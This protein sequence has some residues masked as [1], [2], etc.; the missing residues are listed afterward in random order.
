MVKC[1][2]NK[3][4]AFVQPKSFDFVLWL[5]LYEY[6]ELLE[7]LK[8]ISFGFQI[9]ELYLP[10]KIIDE[11]YEIPYIVHWCSPNMATHIKMHNFQRLGR[12]PSSLIRKCS[13]MLFAFDAHFTKQER[14]GA[15]KFVKVYTT[16]YVLEGMNTMHVQM[17][18]AVVPKFESVISCWNCIKLVVSASCTFTKLISY[19]LHLRGIIAMTSS[20]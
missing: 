4:P 1:L 2:E 7:L 8:T 6:I 14:C 18:K 10:Q 17:A 15:R 20:L 13:P 16:Y 3:V 9:I 19:K 12:S 5:C 11:I